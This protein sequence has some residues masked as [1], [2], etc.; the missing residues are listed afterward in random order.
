MKMNRRTVLGALALLPLGCAP[1]PVAVSRPAPRAPGGRLK[2]L[3]IGAHPDDPESGC[4]GT[5]ARYIAA[6]HEVTLLYL[7]A[8]ENGISGTPWPDAGR[9]RTAEAKEACAVLGAKAAF[10]GQVNGKVEVTDATTTA[11]RAAFDAEKPDVVFTHWPMDTDW[12][13][14]A[15]AI[16][17]LRAYLGTP[18]AVPLYYYE[19]ETGSQTLG[20][21]PS[22]YVDITATRDKK[23]DAL[24][25]H[26]SQSFE[27]LYERHH[28][29]MEAFRGR[30][31]GVSAAEAF[32]TLGPDARSGSL[33]GL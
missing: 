13:H 2:V 33:P 21:A 14:Q 7:T 12:E 6:G 31:L 15:C 30:E 29:K 17:T 10:V 22:T 16:L 18:R 28:E 27:G 20:F 26:K 4:G 3:G 24:K 9:I 19:V 5:L 32:A 11:F 1:A 23:I 25:A 8:G